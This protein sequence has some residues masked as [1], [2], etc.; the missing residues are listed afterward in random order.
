MQL[1]LPPGYQTLVPLDRDKHRKLGTAEAKRGAFVGGLHGV[2]LMLAEFTHAARHYP[3][4][5]VREP[6]SGRF[7]ALAVT[8]L[9]PGKN[10]FAD[11]SG[12]WVEHCYVPAYVRRWPFFTAPLSGKGT[13]EKPESIVLVD[14]TAVGE[15]A[16]PFFDAEGHD[17]EAWTRQDALIRELEGL[18]PAHDRFVQMLVENRLLQ[19]FDAHAFP[20]GGRDLHLTGMHRIDEN[21]LNA[22]EGRMVKGLMKRGELSR[23]YA[24][25]MS[26]DNFRHLMDRASQRAS[27]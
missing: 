25:L 9:E 7:V 19:P 17:T 8:G 4:V 16:E 24:H 22:L 10:L 11:A 14:E 15:S 21:R 3:I 1:P 5:F 23:I 20:K 6:S 2:H 18:R 12:K 13:P 26:L 27:A